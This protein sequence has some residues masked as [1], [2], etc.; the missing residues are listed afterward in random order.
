M[1]SKEIPNEPWKKLWSLV[2]LWSIKGKRKYFTIP[3]FVI[4]SILV[5]FP[6]LRGK[7][8]DGISDLKNIFSPKSYLSRSE[9]DV[10]DEWIAYIWEYPDEKDAESHKD[11]FFKELKKL[12]YR[13]GAYLND[14]YIVRSIEEKGIW[15]LVVDMG[16]GKSSKNDVDKEIE[17]IKS[18]S[19]HNSRQMGSSIIQHLQGAKPVFYDL[20]RFEKI[21]GKVQNIEE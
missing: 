1:S 15:W 8:N 6:V 18:F 14:I 17:G 10:I 3:I 5:V 16:R 9:D 13:N 19:W 11:D 4:I 20:D 2:W 21:Y 12:K 7:V